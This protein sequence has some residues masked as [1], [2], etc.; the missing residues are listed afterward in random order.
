MHQTERCATSSKS[1]ANLEVVRQVYEAAARRDSVTILTLYDPEVELDA[2]AANGTN[3]GKR[4]NTDRDGAL[5]SAER[6]E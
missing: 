6:T 2:S 5:E 1:E 4:S 3:R